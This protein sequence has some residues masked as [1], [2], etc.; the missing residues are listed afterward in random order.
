MTSAFPKWLEDRS[1]YEKFPKWNQGIFS[2]STSTLQITDKD[3]EKMAKEI[4]ET[5]VENI[6]EVKE[7]SVARDKDWDGLYER[8]V[9]SYITDL[10]KTASDAVIKTFKKT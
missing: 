5:A 6:K 10:T 8:Y 7:V 2:F 4:G 1:R 9:E 3:L